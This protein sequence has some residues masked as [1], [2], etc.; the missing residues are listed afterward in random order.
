MS[1]P[2][3]DLMAHRKQ[4][5]ILHVDDN[6]ATRYTIGRTLGREGFK[7][8]E[9]ATGREALRLA[10]EGPDL[11]ILDVKLPDIGGFEVCQRIK[12]D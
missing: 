3:A 9:A 4:T 1:D 11:V 12:A 5:V 6:P 10:K 8:R 2:M 7:V